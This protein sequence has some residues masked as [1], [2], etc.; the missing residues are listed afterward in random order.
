MF[1]RWIYFGYFSFFFGAFNGSTWKLSSENSTLSAFECGRRL[2]SI[3]DSGMLNIA[4]GLFDV[5]R[6]FVFEHFFSVR[7]TVSTSFP[8]TR[9]NV[10]LCTQCFA[11]ILIPLI[12]FNHNNFGYFRLLKS[13]FVIIKVM[14]ILFTG[15]II[16]LQNSHLLFVQIFKIRGKQNW[17]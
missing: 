8:T 2:S 16:W 3:F 1:S 12:I 17:Y 5:V 4:M 13:V 11:C 6:T 10:V 9:F 7:Q 15:I 14:Q